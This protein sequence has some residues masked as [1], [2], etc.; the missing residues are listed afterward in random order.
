[1]AP[2]RPGGLDRY[3][4]S[5]LRAYNEKLPDRYDT[6]PAVRFFRP[7]RMDDFVLDA[8]GQDIAGYAILDV[9]CAT[10]RLLER[11]AKA[12]ARKL[13]GSD[14]APRIL[15]VARRKLLQ[16]DLEPDLRSADVEVSLPW[17]TDTFDVV[18][19]TGVMHHLGAPESALEEIRRVLRPSGKIIVGDACFFPPVREVINLCLRAMPHDGDRHFHTGRQVRRILCNC[20][21][22]IC[23]SER[24]NLWY[25]A[26][27]ARPGRDPVSTSGPASS[28][29]SA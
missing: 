25:F 16:F 4:A 23:R 27:V 10:G 11:L 21:W 5:N 7:S 13:A 2:E 19:L 6:S 9:G 3:R 20:G 24:L 15:D 17:P 12:G 29:L 26:V 28:L 14:V 22:Q 1:V 8:L 18:T